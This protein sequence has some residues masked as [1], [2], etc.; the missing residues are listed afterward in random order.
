MKP[1]RAA[2]TGVRVDFLTSVGE[3]DI[4]TDDFDDLNPYLVTGQK[5]GHFHWVGRFTVLEYPEIPG[6]LEWARPAIE[7]LHHMHKLQPLGER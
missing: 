2:N 6:H 1:N 5:H 4:W 7:L 3:I